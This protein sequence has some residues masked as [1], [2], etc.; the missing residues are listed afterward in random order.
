[1]NPEDLKLS[2]SINPF[3]DNIIILAELAQF[4]QLPFNVL[5]PVELARAQ[6]IVNSS[7]KTFYLNS[8]VLLRQLLA[9][10]LNKEPATFHFQYQPSGKPEL[11]DQSIHFNVTHSHQWIGFSFSRHPIGL[12]IEFTA[13]QKRNFLAI[14]RRFFTHNETEFL[15]K[16]AEADLKTKFFT[17]WTQKEAIL[18]AHGGGIKTG[19]EKIDF[20]KRHHCI[21]SHIYHVEHAQLS[22]ELHCAIATEHDLSDMKSKDTPSYFYILTPTLEILPHQPPYKQNI[23]L[24]PESL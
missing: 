6:S 22:D 19:L 21:N 7:A 12:D 15:S 1:M 20:I 24:I 10:F 9:T 23:S 8:K 11:R 16:Q 4:S 13:F 2:L 5:S 3:S 17:F 14:A 18:K